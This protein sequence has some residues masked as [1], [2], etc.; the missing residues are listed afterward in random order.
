MA[1]PLFSLPHET[2]DGV[3]TVDGGL[4]PL[5]LNAW[6]AFADWAHYWNN[7]AGE[8]HQRY[9]QTRSMEGE[10]AR[11]AELGFL[12]TFMGARQA[13]GHALSAIAQIRDQAVGEPAAVAMNMVA[14][15]ILRIPLGGAVTSAQLRWAAA[16]ILSEVER[17]LRHEGVCEAGGRAC[18]E[19]VVEGTVEGLGGCTGIEISG[20]GYV[21]VDY[22]DD[23]SPIV[24]VPVSMGRTGMGVA[25]ALVFAAPFV[26]KIIGYTIA[27]VVVMQV[28]R[29]T[30]DRLSQY[31]GVNAE[32]QE[33]AAEAAQRSYEEAIVV[34]HQITDP[35]ARARCL[36]DAEQ[37]LIDALA[38]INQDFRGSAGRVMGMLLTVGALGLGAYVISK[39]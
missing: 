31:F 4:I 9:R 24:C 13:L 21:T 1:Q 36:G 35:V 28:A 8:Y 15:P 37:S 27:A 7:R 32:L 20:G 14:D 3:E 26:V 19:T 12:G 29:L 23:G 17:S 10:S 38:Q 30:I 33:A 11:S 5:D 18:S 2:Y 6:T 16:R 39:Q 22:R 34:C 25:P